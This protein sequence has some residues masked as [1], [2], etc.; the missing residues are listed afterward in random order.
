LIA[1]RLDT[2]V[3]GSIKLGISALSYFLIYLL[4]NKLV[5]SAIKTNL[6]Q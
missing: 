6:S 3:K 5:M 4:N 2:A 1:H